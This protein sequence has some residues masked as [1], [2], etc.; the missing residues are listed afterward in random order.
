MI[1][2]F[3]SGKGLCLF[4][5]TIALMLSL[6][7]CGGGGGGGGGGSSSSSG[8]S[9][10][11]GGS[12]NGGVVI[13]ASNAANVGGVAMAVAGGETASALVSVVGVES[14]TTAKPRLITRALEQVAAQAANAAATPQTVVGT[15]ETVNCSSGTA[16]ID[17]ASDG[18]SG[19]ITFN[20]CA[21][22]SGETLNGTVTITGLS[23][24]DDFNFQGTFSVS[25]TFTEPGS[26]ALTMNGDFSITQTCSTTTNCTT[27]LAGSSLRLAFASTS[28]TL[29]NFTLT[30]A[31]TD[32]SV[33]TSAN[34]TVSVT[35]STVNGSLTLVTTTPVLLMLGDQNASAGV[36]QVTG[37]NSK[38]VVTVLSN[39]ASAPA[40]V[41]VDV[42]ADNNGVYEFM[43]T[44]P[45]A[46]ITT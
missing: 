5:S 29:S 15:I 41:E 16:S 1:E 40:A 43:K 3:G 38:A 22:A 32:K 21:N 42:D 4:A 14:T 25:M 46:Q 27:T 37:L 39:S 12:N 30:E 11:P 26:A 9:G 28:L 23:K 6:V 13:T 34:L 7:G 33:T 45:W 20:A 8:G 17:L 18:K 44:Y 19:T 2:K 36:V 24:P 35:S 10:G 31:E